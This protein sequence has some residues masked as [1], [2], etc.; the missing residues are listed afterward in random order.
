MANSVTI[1]TTAPG[2]KQAASDIKGLKGSIQSLGSR[3]G[4]PLGGAIGG[5]AGLG[6]GLATAGI[7]GGLAFDAMRRL[8]DMLVQGVSSALAEEQ[9][10]KRLDAAL[11]ANVKGWDGNRDAIDEAVESRMDLGFSDDALRDSMVKLVVATRDE[12]RA[13]RLQ[14]L[15]MDVARGRG[16]DLAAA[17]DIVVKAQNGQVGALRRLGIQIDSNATSQEALNLLTERYAGQAEAFGETTVGKLTKANTA[18]EELQENVGN[19]LL[20]MLGDTA[21][22]ASEAAE[23]IERLFSGETWVGLGGEKQLAVIEKAGQELGAG[24]GNSISDGFAHSNY[25]DQITADWNHEVTTAANAMEAKAVQEAN[26][27]AGGFAA[28]LA[29]AVRG[30]KD[31]VADAMED[32]TFALTNPLAVARE[33]ARIEGALTSEELATGLSSKEAWVR[34]AARQAVDTL[35]GQWEG[36]RGEAYRGGRA[37]GD[38]L[39]D[40]LASQSG[41]VSEQARHI[42]EL[43]RRI[44]DGPISVNTRININNRLRNSGNIPRF[45]EGG[46]LPAGRIGVVGEE[47]PELIEGGS[48]G[49]RITPLGGGSA[50]GSMQVVVM[51]TNREVNASQQHYRLMQAGRSSF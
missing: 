47:G 21:V 12:E 22:K 35:L 26:R 40:G 30:N 17:T 11:E 39:A 24:L 28:E 18:V 36:L 10:L 13:L 23:A 32:L 14:N 1:R 3:T 44:L 9:S 7:V 48:G 19:I 42:R 38:Q 4:G 25:R 27:V 34:A 16:I 20:P 46:F 33:L 5:L 29:D 8:N 51:L 45:A 15:A 31:V 2:A 41:N 50:S 37:T 6:G 49:S 43:I